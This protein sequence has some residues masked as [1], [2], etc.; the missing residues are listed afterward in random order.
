MDGHRAAQHLGQVAGGDGDFATEV[1]RPPR[2]PWQI[3]PATMGQVL[4]GHH[5][6]SG[7]HYLQENR[8]EARQAYD[9]EQAVFEPGSSAQVCRPV[10]RIH[11]AHADKHGRPS[12]R[13][14]LPQWM[15]GSRR[16][17]NRTVKPLQRAKLLSCFG[18]V[19]RAFHLKF[20]TGVRSRWHS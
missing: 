1:V 16:N 7:G 18:Y 11:V 3:V 17:A 8:H 19:I 4:A 20:S 9:K 13:E 15:S 10:P 5:A 2:P 12:E 14:I 6:E